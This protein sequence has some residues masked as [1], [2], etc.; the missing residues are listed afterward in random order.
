MTT[1]APRKRIRTPEEAFEAG[2]ELRRR[3]GVK[4]SPVPPATGGTVRPL[5]AKPRRRPA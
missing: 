5:A 3:Q 4:P 1:A 2:R